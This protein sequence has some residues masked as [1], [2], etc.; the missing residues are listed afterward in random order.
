MR[1]ILDRRC[2]RSMPE[3]LS[4]HPLAL[5]ARPTWNP[6]SIALRHRASEGA[7]KSENNGRFGTI[8][9]VP[10]PM[11]PL[12]W[13]LGGV[14]H[15]RFSAPQRLGMTSPSPVPQDPCDVES[16][17]YVCRFRDLFVSRR[18]MTVLFRSYY[19]IVKGGCHQTSWRLPSSYEAARDGVTIYVRL[20]VPSA[21]HLSNVLLK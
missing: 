17:K 4:C 21:T 20:I 6:D 8:R 11:P 10:R 12:W 18:K 9:L 19:W 1:E 5:S 13:C 3:Y 2:P 7:S 15:F 16:S 14:S